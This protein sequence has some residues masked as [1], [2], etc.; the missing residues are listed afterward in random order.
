MKNNLMVESENGKISYK[1]LVKIDAMDDEYI[2]YTSNELNKCGDIVC[3]VASY[4]FLDGKQKL[5]PIKDEKTLEML[6]SILEHVQN[7]MNK[8]EGSD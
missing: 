2:I 8:K 4:E 7:M 3:Y 6:D 1:P 5:R